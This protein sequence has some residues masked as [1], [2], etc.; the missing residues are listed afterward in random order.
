MLDFE[1]VREILTQYADELPAEIFKHLDG[2]IILLPEYKLHPESRREDRLHI[3]GEYH[4]DPRGLGRYITIYYG[5]FERVYGSASTATLERKL[6]EVLHHELT[7]HIESLAGDYSLER[8]D[9]EQLD[10]YHGN[11]EDNGKP[12]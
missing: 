2:G 6:R 10:S 5:S 1:E 8:W 9:V 7:H 3:M 12:E 11:G 4:V